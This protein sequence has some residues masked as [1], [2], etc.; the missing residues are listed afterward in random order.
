MGCRWFWASDLTTRRHVV[1]GLVGQ[2]STESSTQGV[3]SGGWFRPHMIPG[4]LVRLRGDDSR[5]QGSGGVRVGRV[6]G[7]GSK[8]LHCMSLGCWTLGNLQDSGDPMKSTWLCHIRGDLSLPSIR[9]LPCL[10]VAMV[11]PPPSSTTPARLSKLRLSRCSS[12]VQG[13]GSPTR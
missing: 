8:R 5:A 13:P 10:F 11:M 6:C 9:G 4:Y 1:R 12:A 3:G 7:D 2:H